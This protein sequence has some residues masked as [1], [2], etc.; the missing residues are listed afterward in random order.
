MHRA[1]PSNFPVDQ[2]P[3]EWYKVEATDDEVSTSLL[4]NV[5][6]EDKSLA[7]ILS[8]SRPQELPPEIGLLVQIYRRSTK[9][10][11]T[12]KISSERQQG[13]PPRAGDIT[14]DEDEKLALHCEILHRVKVSRDTELSKGY[15][16]RSGGLSDGQGNTSVGEGDDRAKFYQVPGILLPGDGDEEIC[17]GETLKN[18]QIWYVDGLSTDWTKPTPIQQGSSRSNSKEPTQPARRRHQI[19]RKLRSRNASG[20][21]VKQTEEA[22]NEAEAAPEMRRGH[23]ANHL[24]SLLTPYLADQH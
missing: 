10:T 9:I 15:R 23:T 4:E 19:L 6:S 3:Q 1:D 16:H 14:I 21:G 20:A 5:S 2:G 7:I 13:I 12:Q 8:R 24:R 18:D 11:P 17:I 22:Q